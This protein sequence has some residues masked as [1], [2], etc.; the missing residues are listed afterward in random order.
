M[1]TTG[2]VNPNRVGSPVRHQSAGR[3]LTSSRY[4]VGWE[5]EGIVKVGSTI[6]GR[7]RY[8][9]FL[10]RGA[11]LIEVAYYAEL[12]D[13]LDAEVWLQRRLAEEFPPAFTNRTEADPFLPN[14]GGW[15]ECFAIP[16]FVW[17]RVL[18]IA[19]E[20]AVVA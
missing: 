15:T 12:M 11:R 4:I 6:L 5:T 19:N 2:R 18:D 10:S 1:R 14:G 7:T 16:A 8:G 17:P 13:S 20:K 9:A 3:W